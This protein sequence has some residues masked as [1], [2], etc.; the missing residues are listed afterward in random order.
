[1]TSTTVSQPANAGSPATGEYDAI[2]VGAGFAGMY[3]LIKLRELGFSARVIEAGTEVGGTWYWN[4]YPGARCDVESLDYQYSFSDE[5]QREWNWTERYA[6]QP[7][8]LRYASFVADKFDLR[9]DIQFQTRVTSARWDEREARWNIGT[10]RQDQYRAKFLIAGTGCLSTPSLPRLEGM[11]SFKGATYHTGKWPHEGVDFTGK[12]VAVIGTGSSGIQSIPVIAQQAK[13]LYV[14]QRTP[15]F[16]L[17]AANYMLTREKA[18]HYRNHFQEI[19]AEARRSVAGIPITPSDRS[20]HDVAADER[21][22][23]FEDRWVQGGFQMLQ[24]YKDLVMT[25]EANEIVAEFVRSKIRE[26]VKDPEVAADLQPRDHPLG[27]KRICIDTDYYTT[28]NRENVQLINIR[29]HPITAITPKGVKTAEA[30]YEVDAIVYATGFDAMTGAL[31]AMKIEGKGGQKLNEKWAAGPRTYLG[32]ASAGFPN[33][34]TITGPGS[35]SVFSNMIVSIEQHVEWIA[36][37]MRSMRERG[38]GVIDASPDAEDAWVAHVNELASMTLYPQANSWYL[39]A[40][41]PGKPRVFMPYVGGVGAYREK[42]DAVA[43]AGYE[44][45]TLQPAAVPA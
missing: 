26:A 8:I 36:E 13:E 33:M 14:F 44:G 9:R 2:V 1:V 25:N 21:N 30:E 37:A 19:K 38:Y 24:A 18:E 42:C 45:F 41:I 40:N 29:K 22:R 11:D 35:P 20:V 6:T 27:T 39:G 7:E 23:E 3:M 43:R 28:Y 34:F 16:S 31:F 5:L 32:L 17:P 10:D 12:R 15:N 4:R